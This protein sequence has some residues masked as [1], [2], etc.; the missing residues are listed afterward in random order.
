MGKGKKENILNPKV[1]GHRLLV[2]HFWYPPPPCISYALAG[3]GI[4]VT[5]IFWWGW[6]GV[7]AGDDE[8]T[9]TKLPFGICCT[10]MC[11]GCRVT[12]RI[13]PLMA[14][15]MNLQLSRLPLHCLHKS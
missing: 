12:V 14:L 8:M 5:E 15:S 13:E 1:L 6:G 4:I 11:N 3:V 9:I 10:G 7:W 2:S